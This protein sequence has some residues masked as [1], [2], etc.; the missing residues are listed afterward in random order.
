MSSPAPSFRELSTREATAVLRRNN[1]G[2]LAFAFRR[3]VEIV[4]VHY[5]YSGGWVYGRTS[6]GLRASDPVPFRDVL[7]RI[8]MDELSGRAA[9]T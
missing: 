8:H 4:P 6:L 3:R 5:V 7:F 9:D 2:R 1:V